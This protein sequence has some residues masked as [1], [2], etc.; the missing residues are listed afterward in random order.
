MERC[1]YCDI[2]IDTDV[3]GFTVY[4]DMIYCEDC[5]SDLHLPIEWEDYR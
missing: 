3:D 5:A 1:V 2:I 4:T